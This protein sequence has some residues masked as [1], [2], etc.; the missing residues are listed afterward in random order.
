MHFPFRSHGDAGRCLP[1][2]PE[3][4]QCNFARRIRSWPRKAYPENAIFTGP[5]APAILS[6]ALVQAQHWSATSS[7]CHFPPTAPHST[8][9]HGRLHQPRQHCASSLQA[10]KQRWTQHCMRS[11]ICWGQEC[12]PSQAQHHTASAGKLRPRTASS[13]VV[14]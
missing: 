8:A 4:P 6:I 9:Q 7:I 5:Q 11:P 13:Q 10:P 12:D 2:A 1:H 14:S 3:P